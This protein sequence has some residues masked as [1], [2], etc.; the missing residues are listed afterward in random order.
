MMGSL[1]QF[2]DSR[3]RVALTSLV[4]C[5]LL[6]G[7]GLGLDANPG[8]LTAVLQAF[9]LGIFVSQLFF[10]LALRRAFQRGELVEKP[11]S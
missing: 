3:P 4:I 7:I 1:R 10:Q 11:S 2:A 9:S 8:S 5:S 6:A